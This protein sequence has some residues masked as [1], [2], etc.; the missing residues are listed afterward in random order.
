M[1]KSMVSE[2]SA[3]LK[4]M[5]FLI[6]QSRR[7]TVVLV[8]VLAW[9]AVITSADAD[10]MLSFQHTTVK[11][12]AVHEGKRIPVEF[13]FTNQGDEPLT[14]QSVSTSCGCTTVDFPKNPI[15][16]GRE[17]LIRTVFD[18]KGHAGAKDILLLVKSNDTRK[19]TCALHIH[20]YVRRRWKIEPDRFVLMSLKPEQRYSTKV[21]VSNF[22]KAPLLIR[23]VE[24]E[25]AFVRLDSSPET[26]P[27]QASE[28]IHFSVLTH[29]WRENKMQQTS[30]KV[31]ADDPYKVFE[32]IPILVKVV[33]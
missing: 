29:G 20:G 8:V 26:I 32:E 7:Y 12:G 15:M 1:L 5:R 25:A 31:I 27:P 9:L 14:I 2:I 24:S 17:G 19:E 11:M 16:P 18:S 13:A 23:G 33:P 6:G 22:G 30:L 10:P 4:G 3:S 21:A 28:E